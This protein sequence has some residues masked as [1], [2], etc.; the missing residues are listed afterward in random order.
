MIKTI[1]PECGKRIALRGLN[2][3]LRFEHHFSNEEAKRI[4]KDTRLNKELNSFEEETLETLRRLKEI[5]ND[6]DLIKEFAPEHG[7]SFHTVDFENRLIDRLMMEY[8]QTKRYI[9]K[10]SLNWDSVHS[11]LKA[12]D[13]IESG[14]IEDD[15][16]EGSEEK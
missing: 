2:G 9:F 13:K 15:V 3:H 14:E 6:I 10:L 1:C 11:G 7:V 5:V 12:W 8:D 16:P 4:A